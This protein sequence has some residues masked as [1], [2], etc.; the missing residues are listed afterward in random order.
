M[1]EL[2]SLLGRLEDARIR[3]QRMRD[4]REKLAAAIAEGERQVKA[5]LADVQ[6]E[7]LGSKP[8]A[9]RVR[10]RTGEMREGVIH[11][12][13]AEDAMRVPEIA[14]RMSATTASVYACLAALKKE[15]IVV[16][17]EDHH[18]GLTFEER[19]RRRIAGAGESHAAV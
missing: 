18:F 10:H 15:G 9:G 11:L 4:Q 14:A 19:D 3:L 12:L 6:L 2:Q 16:A 8:A 13:M 17:L 1:A 5:I 7:A